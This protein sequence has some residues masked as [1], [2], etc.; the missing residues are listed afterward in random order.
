MFPKKML[1]LHFVL[2]RLWCSEN[3]P[4]LTSS[5]CKSN[6]YGLKE[7]IPKQTTIQIFSFLFFSTC[8]IFRYLSLLGAPVTFVLYFAVSD[9]QWRPLVILIHTAV[10]GAL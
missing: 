5:K 6:L 7:N 1:I 10:G 4:D 9:K 8:L 3:L 2:G